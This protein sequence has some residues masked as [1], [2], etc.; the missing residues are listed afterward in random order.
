M[1]QK[2]LILCVVCTSFL[3]SWLATIYR[4]DA[5]IVPPFFLVK[6]VLKGRW[7]FTGC[8]VRHENFQAYI[9]CIF[10][11]CFDTCAH[12]IRCM[13]NSLLTSNCLIF[14]N[15][16][17]FLFFRLTNTHLSVQI[18]KFWVG[19]I[20]TCISNSE[21]C[22][23]LWGGTLLEG[24]IVLASVLRTTNGATEAWSDLTKRY[25]L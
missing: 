17:H 20:L 15:D 24:G 23:K 11:L 1:T 18:S 5:S 22:S 12:H 7:G 21:I 3:M 6:F 14:A 16:R 25:R 13:N 9:A 2:S 19:L 4:T 8:Q 10:C